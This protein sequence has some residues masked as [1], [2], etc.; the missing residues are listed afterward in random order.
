MSRRVPLSLL[1]VEYDSGDRV[2]ALFALVSQTP[3]FI[4]VA[5]AT[6]LLSRRDLATASLLAGQLLN[7]VFNYALKTAIE[8]PRPDGAPA[9]APAHGMPSNHAQF[10][11]FWAAALALWAARR[12]SSSAV[13]RALV[14]V[15]AIALAV[16]VCVSRL[17]LGYHTRA[18]VVVGAAVGALA[19]AGW[20][21]FTETALRPLFASVVALKLA[22]IL[23]IR[24]CSH[25]NVLEAEFGAVGGRF[26][27]ETTL[28][29]TL[30]LDS[31][32]TFPARSKSR[33][34]RGAASKSPQTSAGSPQVQ[35]GARVRPAHAK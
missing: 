25:A 3:I 24:D 5:F 11:G 28:R 30:T 9:H 16:A 12:W 19:G 15:G 35:S 27:T 22:K 14:V 34:A 33:S 18:Q 29:P 31:V 4:M 21:L 2:G 8:E 13:E 32:E 10:M 20:H 6:L 17:Y 1:H 26:Y 7:E 23:Y